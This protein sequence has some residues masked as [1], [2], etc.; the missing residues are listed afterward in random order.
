[1]SGNYVAVNCKTNAFDL[2][3]LDENALDYR[4][5]ITLMWSETSNVDHD[6]I[7]RMVSQMTAYQ[8]AKSYKLTPKEVQLFSNKHGGVSVV[9][10]VNHGCLSYIHQMLSM[11]GMTHTFPEYVSHMSITYNTPPLMAEEIKRKAE[12]ILDDIVIQLDDIVAE[13]AKAL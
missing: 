7:K 1:M 2:L 11:L 6:Y 5:H 3:G 13:D 9:L 8:L 4:P 10:V 12:L